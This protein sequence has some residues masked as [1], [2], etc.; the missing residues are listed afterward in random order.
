MAN[1]GIIGG[2]PWGLALAAA[3][4][5]AGSNTLLFT[6]RT[7][8]KAPSELGDGVKTTQTLTDLPKHARLLV[9]ATPSAVIEDIAKELG[10]HLDGSHYVVHGIRGLAGE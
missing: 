4:A 9:L 7:Q 2:G 8:D 10:R 6:R 1:V 5:R 3:A